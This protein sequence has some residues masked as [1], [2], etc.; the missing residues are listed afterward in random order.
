MSIDLKALGAFTSEELVPQEVTIGGEAVTVYVRVLP[1]VEI[2][3]F[4][5][6]TRDTDMNIRVQSIP[7]V[8]AKCIRDEDG[9]PIFSVE[10]AGKLKPLVRKEFLQAFK[11]VNGGKADSG[12]D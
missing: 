3:R 5:E 12:N 2:D 4:V 8:L 9:K 6:E 11:A 7:R 10:M 1:S